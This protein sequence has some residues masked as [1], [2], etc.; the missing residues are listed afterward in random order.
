MVN[1]GAEQ[2][3]FCFHTLSFSLSISFFLNLFFFID[4]KPFSQHQLCVEEVNDPAKQ[5]HALLW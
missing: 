2:M 3:M 5:Q 1:A 4:E